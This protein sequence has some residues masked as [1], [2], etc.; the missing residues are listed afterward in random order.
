MGKFRRI[1]G[2]VYNVENQN[3]FNNALYDYFQAS[4]KEQPNTYTK[5]KIREMIRDFPKIYPRTI[6]I[7]D[8]SFE[9]GCVYIEDFDLADEANTYMF[10]N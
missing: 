5:R 7:V 10:N 3:G 8:M 9:C 2:H 4:D 1:T 6:V